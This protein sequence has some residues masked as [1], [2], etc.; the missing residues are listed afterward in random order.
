VFCL[1]PDENTGLILDMSRSSTPPPPLKLLKA[2][3]FEEPTLPPAVPAFPEGWRNRCRWLW[4]VALAAIV[5]HSNWIVSI[6]FHVGLGLCLA[7]AIVRQQGEAGRVGIEAVLGEAPPVESFES[8]LNGAPL[9]VE[10][11]RAGE[12]GVAATVGTHPTRQP[13]ELSFNEVGTGLAPLG[14]TGIGTGIGN[15]GDGPGI[16][17]TGITFFGTQA[18]GNSFVYIVDK[19]GSMEGG[20]FRRALSELVRSVGKLKGDQ[21]VFVIFFSDD[22]YPMFSPK[23]SKSMIAAS[24]NNKRRI[25]RWA[26]YQEPGGGT[27]PAGSLQMALKLHPDAIFL[28][29]DGELYDAD[30]VVEMLRV[31]NKDKVSIHTI[32]FESDAGTGTLETIAEENRGSYRFVL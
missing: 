15:D 14:T 20:R 31:L 19:S 32:A 29:T 23:V 8:L 9:V 3:A 16:K 21:Q 22:T 12:S 18:A 5:S 11:P 10:P 24:P 27:N 6:L 13:V 4:A 7:A 28:L 25:N 1:N 26:R 2:L 30:Y 17:G